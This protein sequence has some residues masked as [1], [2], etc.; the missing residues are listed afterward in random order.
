MSK[1]N[2]VIAMV[3]GLVIGIGSISSNAETIQRNYNY[4][5]TYINEETTQSEETKSYVSP[6][7]LQEL[8]YNSRTNIYF[9]NES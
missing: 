7:Y 2:V 4:T 9:G 6:E 5:I 3:V 8:E 1:R